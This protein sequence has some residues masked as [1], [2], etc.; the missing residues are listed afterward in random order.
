MNIFIHQTTGSNDSQFLPRDAM[1][2][3]GLCRRVV[4]VYLSVCLSVMFVYSVEKNKPI[5]KYF[6][7]SGSHTILILP[8]QTL[9]QYSDAPSKGVECGWGRQNSRLS[10]DI[11]LHR[12]LSTVRPPSVIHTAAPDHGKLVTHIADKWR[13]LFFAGDHDEVFMTRSLITPKT[14]AQHLIVY[15]AMNLK[16]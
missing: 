2:K 1:H 16:P 3:H 8:N 7:P 11:W 12:V 15:A 5:C 10:I 4:S 14:T 9:A 13:L 6:L